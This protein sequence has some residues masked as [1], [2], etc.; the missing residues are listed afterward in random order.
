MLHR[1]PL[2]TLSSWLSVNLLIT[3]LLYDDGEKM[4]QTPLK[5]LTLEAFL[6]LPE[7]KPASEFIAGQIVQKPRPQGKH[8]T[9]QSD[10]GAVVNAALKPNRIARAY[11]EL[12]CTFGGRSIVPDLAVFR[13]ERIPRD[14]DG[15][16]ANV[17]DL[18]PDWTIKIL[19]P[20]Q[21]QTKVVLNILHCLVH[22]AEMGWLID[23][24]EHLVFVYFADHTIAV[25]NAADSE[26]PVPTFAQNLNL[27]VGE[28][29]SWLAA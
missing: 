19:S 9:M 4:V 5:R 23:P 14:P 21:S 1:T 18:A 25:F 26:I 15:Q 27:T 17:F 2:S 22:G 11:P 20:A 8:S 24:E 28:L 3:P 7:T 10:L 13:W 16:V 12:R 6:A 29:F